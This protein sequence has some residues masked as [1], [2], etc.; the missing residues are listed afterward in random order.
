METT[1]R[2]NVIL[3]WN[4]LIS[5]IGIILG[6]I[7]IFADPEDILKIAGIILGIYLIFNG[8]LIFLSSTIQT[9]LME[10]YNNMIISII[11]FILGILLL[12]VHHYVFSIVAGIFL[13]IIPIY[14][15]IAN[16]QHFETFKKEIVHL[17]LGAI[18][19]FCGINT[20]TKII[21]YILGGLVILLSI[22]YLIFFLINYFK[23][24]HLIKKKEQENSVID[25]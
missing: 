8:V 17:V 19:I 24:K 3:F 20:L 13:I 2:N 23:A 15:I 12:F 1:N 18:L 14:R 7:F 5:I 21:F 6:I 9:T 10:K 22:V 4:I 25:V 11:L 16:H